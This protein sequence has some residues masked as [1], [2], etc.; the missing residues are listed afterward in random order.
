[1]AVCQ[2]C[3]YGDF[4]ASSAM[5]TQEKFQYKNKSSWWGVVIVGSASVAANADADGG[6]GRLVDGDP[7]YTRF[8]VTTSF[9][10]RI[11]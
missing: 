6:G 2:N 8:L 9:G 10:A 3:V 5:C 4:Y 1:V 11:V 7:N